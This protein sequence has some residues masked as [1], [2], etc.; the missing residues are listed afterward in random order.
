M[1]EPV[2]HGHASSDAEARLLEQAGDDRAAA[3]AERLVEL[4]W[5]MGSMSEHFFSAEVLS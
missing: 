4:R 3:Q 2:E 5:S 1:P